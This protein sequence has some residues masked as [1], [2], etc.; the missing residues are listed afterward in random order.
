MTTTINV[1]VADDDRPA[2]RVYFLPPAMPAARSRPEKFMNVPVITLLRAGR[3]AGLPTATV[4]P[5]AGFF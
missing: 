3:P 5:L 1:A 2:A 4:H